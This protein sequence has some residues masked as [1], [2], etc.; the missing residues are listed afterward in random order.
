MLNLCSVLLEFFL[1][2]GQSLDK[3][4]KVDIGY[5]ASPA[6]PLNYDFEA[7]LAGGQIGEAGFNDVGCGLV[8]VVVSICSLN[9][10][11]VTLSGWGGFC[12][13]GS[14]PW[15]LVIVLSLLSSAVV[16]TVTVVVWLGWVL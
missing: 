5:S 16:S 8:V 14:M 12:V 3:L 7:C 13:T 9:Y 10:D 4:E 6:C 11:F 1:P 15:S 2:I